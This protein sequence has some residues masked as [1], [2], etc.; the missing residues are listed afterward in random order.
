MSRS[1]SLYFLGGLAATLVVAFASSLQ[2]PPPS[3]ASR[4]AA[5]TAATADAADPA[6]AAIDDLAAWPAGAGR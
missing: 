4:P 6:Q 3:V 1:R 5:A 2:A